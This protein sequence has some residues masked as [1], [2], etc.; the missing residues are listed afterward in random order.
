M[1]EQ[2]EAVLIA[3]FCVEDGLASKLQY[4]PNST[5]TF[6]R[7]KSTLRFLLNSF[8]LIPKEELEERFL[9]IVEVN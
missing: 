6:D 8:E 5:V 3:R 2:E 1:R 4:N 7:F 9:K